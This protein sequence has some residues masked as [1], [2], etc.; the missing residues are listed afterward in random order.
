MSSHRGAS[1]EFPQYMI[2]WKNKKNTNVFFC[3][4]KS[5][6]SLAVLFLINPK[7]SFILSKEKISLTVAVSVLI[8]NVT[9]AY[10]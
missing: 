5:A 8:K 9:L 7:N 1:K 2:S 4:K 3:Q 6:L 10:H